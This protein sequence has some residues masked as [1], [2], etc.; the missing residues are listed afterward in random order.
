MRK[1]RI[2]WRGSATREI[3]EAGRFAAGAALSIE[4]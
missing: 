3:P 4:L 2:R 1:S